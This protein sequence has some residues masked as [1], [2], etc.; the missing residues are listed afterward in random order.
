MVL[1]FKRPIG[2]RP[3]NCAPANPR[4]LGRAPY[5][6]SL[7]APGA[8]DRR[9]K[10]RQTDLLAVAPFGHP[11][12]EKCDPLVRPRITRTQRHR[13]V[14]QSLRD[15]CTPLLHILV[16]CQVEAANHAG[17]LIRGE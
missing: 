1:G 5:G 8:A 14:S 3:G 4:S 13:F 7:T 15:L 6:S 2:S 16:L 11:P 10:L 17:T 9:Q 12:V